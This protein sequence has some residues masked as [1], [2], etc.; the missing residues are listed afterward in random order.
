MVQKVKEARDTGFG[1]NAATDTYEDLVRARVID[2]LK[3]VRPALQN[4]SSIASFLL[5]TN[6][7]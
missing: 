4:T 1:Y 6:E 5:C 3:V 7:T 2:P